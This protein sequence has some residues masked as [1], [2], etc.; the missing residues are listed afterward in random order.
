ML[1]RRKEHIDKSQLISLFTFH[2]HGDKYYY[3]I[4][5]ITEISVEEI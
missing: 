3:P 1:G 4:K 2:Y 5:T